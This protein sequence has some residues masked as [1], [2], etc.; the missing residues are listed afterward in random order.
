MSIFESTAK[1]E[2]IHEFANRYV[3]EWLLWHRSGSLDA[4][5]CDIAALLISTIHCTY[6]LKYSTDRIFDWIEKSFFLNN[7]SE[8]IPIRIA[9]YSA[10][11]LGVLQ[12]LRPTISSDAK[13]RKLDECDDL[14]R[15]ALPIE[16][17]LILGGDHRLNIDRT[18]L[19]NGYG[20][21]PFPRPEAITFSSSTAT[22]I[23]K[24]A[25]DLVEMRR[26]RFIGDAISNGLSSTV[27][28]LSQE[29]RDGICRQIGL[30]PDIADVIIAASGTDSSLI[31]HGITQL[32]S[33]G[34]MTT[35]IVGIDESGSGV[36]LALQQKHFADNTALSHTVQKGQPLSTAS[37]VE[38]QID[39]PVR[40]ELG[41]AIPATFLD[42]QVRD[43]VTA[44]VESGSHVVVHAMDHS[45]LGYSGPSKALL[46]ELK[47]HFR[48]K[49]SIV[50]DACQMRLDREDI[51]EYLENELI[52]II[53]GSKYFT[54]PPFSGAILV[55]ENIVRHVLEKGAK[56]AAGFNLYCA[57][58]DFS[59][60]LRKLV[61]GH[62]GDVNLG[63]LFR[64]TAAISEMERYFDIP[65][66]IRIKAVAQFCDRVETLLLDAPFLELQYD[67]ACG[68]RFSSMEEGELS[69]RRM[70]FPF[71]LSTLHRD[72][73]KTCTELQMRE[74]YALLNQDCSDLMPYANAREYR[75]LAQ[76]CHVGQPVAIAHR[77]G[78][79]T[80]VLR[81]SVGA[82]VFSESY[83]KNSGRIVS[84]LI[85]DELW[86]IGVILAKIELLLGKFSHDEALR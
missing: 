71:F 59:P 66:L 49:V 61:T 4:R 84:A 15:F 19:L 5:V 36:K 74:I 62:S 42:K 68:R 2:G 10:K 63:S 73:R 17:L 32:I 29:V 57:E 83:S 3:E 6:L 47:K 13:T 27:A 38:S 25:F 53:T 76:K 77:S 12:A 18:S 43:L 26:K 37:I 79:K 55:P 78:L 60:R 86:Q 46:L 69:G 64:W 21:R 33:V 41:E 67:N 40:T 30:G 35:L 45:K 70:I 34:P 8:T 11:T 82:R 72:V 80:A 48:N 50:V 44:G 28:S 39:I 81:I 24:H 20:C 51:V 22:S 75:L 65:P 14:L 52:V 85:E 31:A 7:L 56:L 23:S 9:D 16:R 1:L 54:G 58:Y